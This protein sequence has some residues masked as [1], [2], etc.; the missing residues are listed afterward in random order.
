MAVSCKEIFPSILFTCICFVTKMVTSIK[1]ASIAELLTR[2]LLC[3]FQ[4]FMPALLQNKNQ[5]FYDSNPS[6][7]ELRYFS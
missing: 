2:V 7:A 6:G 4:M 3:K 5:Y 1:T